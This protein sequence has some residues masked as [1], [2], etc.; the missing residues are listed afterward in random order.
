MP[1]P[2]P[3][4]WPF[5]LTHVGRTH[6]SKRIVHCV[7][8]ENSSHHVVHAS[9]TYSVV[10]LLHQLS[11]KDVEQAEILG[12]ASSW[13]AKCMYVGLECV[14]LRSFLQPCNS[15]MQPGDN[16]LMHAII[17][18]DTTDQPRRLTGSHRKRLPTP[19]RS[20][21]EIGN[22]KWNPNP[23]QSGVAWKWVK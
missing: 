20:L 14:S 4:K 12:R 9:T 21:I 17:A 13:S 19:H 6:D 3:S 8:R 1:L 10:S 18:Y 7:R 22:R 16:S 5:S 23:N 11:N 15:C 2:I